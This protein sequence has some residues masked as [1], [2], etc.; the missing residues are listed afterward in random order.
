MIPISIRVPNLNRPRSL[1]LEVFG[2]IKLS[3]FF[4]KNNDKSKDLIVILANSNQN[5]AQRF[6]F[7]LKTSRFMNVEAVSQQDSALRNL[8]ITQE[9]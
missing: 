2:F 7:T 5:I 6:F 3:T 9:T 4:L 1:Q 8:A